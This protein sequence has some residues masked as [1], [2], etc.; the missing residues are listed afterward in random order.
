M[1]IDP[2]ERSFTRTEFCLAE[3]ISKSKFYA[4]KKNH[5]T[6]DELDIDGTRR[7]TA[8]ARRDWRALMLARPQTEA[9]QLEAHRRR[10]AA[11]LAGRIAAASPL[12]VSK[13]N[14]HKPPRG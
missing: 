1:D 9:A 5:L 12:H 6:P 13:Q 7:I 2:S 11:S 8:Q 10:E 14:R 3:R 4:L